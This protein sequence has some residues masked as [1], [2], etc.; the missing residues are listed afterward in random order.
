MDL[1][2]SEEQQMLKETARRFFEKECP[3]TLVRELLE[4]AHGHSPALWRQMVELGWLGLPLPEQ[5]DGSAGSFLDLAVILEEMGR[6]LL[7]GAFFS[8]VLL[9]AYP[10]L[11]AGSAA[12]KAAILPRIAAGELI[13]TMAWLETGAA[14]DPGDVNLT[15][16]ADADGYLLDGVKLFV[17]NA[18]IADMILT[19][20]RTSSGDD[21]HGVSLLLV[22]G[23]DPGVHCTLLKPIDNSKLCQVTFEGVRVPRANVLGEVDGATATIDRA[24]ARAAVAECLQLVGG[25]Q[26]ALDMSVEHVKNRV[27]FGQSVGAFQAVQHHCANMATDLDGA[28]FL[29]YEA[30]WMLSEGMPCTKEVAMAKAWVSDACHRVISRAHQVHGGVGFIAEHDLTLYFKRTKAGETAYGGSNFHYRALAQALGL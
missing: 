29:T 9:G 23:H 16:R 8:T 18:H 15:A 7:P 4:T 10:V 3:K 6:A 22:D 27:Q 28:R 19:V 13:L 2:L 20:V 25:A 30:A 5:Y 12:Q 11:E 21:T 14:Y 26:V 1:A 17:P 24:L